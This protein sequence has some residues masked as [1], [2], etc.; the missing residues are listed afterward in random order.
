MKK[1]FSEQVKKTCGK[2]LTEQKSQTY[3]NAN[4][5]ILPVTVLEVLPL[6]RYR[7]LRCAGASRGTVLVQRVGPSMNGG[8]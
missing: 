8:E 6:H 7:A 4:K 2:T 1:V 5:T 3:Q